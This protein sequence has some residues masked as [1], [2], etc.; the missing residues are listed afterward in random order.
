MCERRMCDSTTKPT[1]TDRPSI[2]SKQINKKNRTWPREKVD[3]AIA[4]HSN[5]MAAHTVRINFCWVSKILSELMHD[6]CTRGPFFF[7]R[8]VDVLSLDLEGPR[9]R[10]RGT[11]NA[12]NKTK[13]NKNRALVGMKFVEPRTKNGRSGRPTRQWLRRKLFIFFFKRRNKKRDFYLYQ[14]ERSEG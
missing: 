10:K 9:K 2:T 7:P 13:M 6:E 14:P 3:G 11:Q 4:R 5:D 1:H 12:E 8:V